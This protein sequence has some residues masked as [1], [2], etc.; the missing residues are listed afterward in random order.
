MSHCYLRFA[1]KHTEGVPEA[2][3]AFLRHWEDA[4]VGNDCLRDTAVL[5]ARLLTQIHQERLEGDYDDPKVSAT[6]GG[7]WISKVNAPL[8]K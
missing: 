8:E 5:A 4:T 3:S 2:L 6:P 1:H 7:S